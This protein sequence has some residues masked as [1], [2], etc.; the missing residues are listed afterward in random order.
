VRE[1]PHLDLRRVQVG[2]AERDAGDQGAERLHF[3]DGLSKLDEDVALRTCEYV[4]RSL[5]FVSS[6]P[7]RGTP[8][9]A[10]PFAKGQIGGCSLFARDLLQ[11]YL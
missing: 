2:V 5:A 8:C 1:K 10:D 7:S 3:I 4:P 9:R 6:F 11:Q